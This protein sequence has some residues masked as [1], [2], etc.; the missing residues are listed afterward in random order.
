MTPTG[1]D[2]PLK[3]RPDI[4]GLRAVAVL[5]VVLF[6]LGLP[7]RGGYVGVD[8][9]FTI[10]GFLIGTIILRETAER[11]FTFAGFYER[12]IRRIFPALFAMLAVS[13]IFAFKYLLPLELVTY[14]RSL[15]AA[16]FSFSNIFFFFQSGYF[17][18]DAATKPL[19]HTWSLAVEEQFY[20]LLPILLVLLRRYLPRR[21]DIALYALTV[22]SFAI[23]LPGAYHHPSAT[24][25][26]PHTR[27]WEL[28]LG[29]VLSLESCPRIRKPILRN[30]GGIAGLALIAFAVFLYHSWTP[31]PGLAALPP[32]LGAALIIA[33]GRSGPNLAGRLLALRPV[34]FV[35]LISYSL[36]LWHWP[37]FVF[38]K[39]GFTLIRGLTHHQSQAYLLVLSLVLAI[40]SWRFIEVPFRTG[41]LRTGRRPLFAG[42]AVVLTASA[43]FA[44]IVAMHAGWQ[45][46]LSPQAA[47]ISSYIVEDTSV[48]VEQYRQ[49]TCFISE[50]SGTLADFHIDPCLTLQPGRKNLLLIGDSHAA[51]LYWGLAHTLPDTHVL[52]ATASGCKP[53]LHQ[54]PRQLSPCSEIMAYALNDFVLTHHVDALLLAAHWDEGDLPS[55]AETLTFL[56]QH[57]IPTILLGPIVQYDA[58]LPRLLTQSLLQ[59][60]PTLPARHR[61]ATIEPLDHQMANLAA[62]TGPTPYISLYNLF[63]QN[64]TCVEYA[65]P[66]TPLQA[67]YG[68]VTRAGSILT[69]QR[70]AA[71]HILP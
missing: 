53:V 63:C 32:C 68:H 25:Y 35:G 20:I 6:H 46:R 45:S 42:A 44:F 65:N 38:Y 29:T 61:L 31:F 23:A 62:T 30:A 54:R 13:S 12:R 7:L 34:V 37:V 58:S 36:Y 19:L 56:H 71:L 43:A 26:W 10:S 67:D 2:T 57:N 33:A 17:D 21:V 49:F 59:H 48:T 64:Q 69:A 27:A 5:S 24:F 11:R 51:D 70:I 50:S 18:T 39:Y 28:L 41:P 14:S 3:Y 40:L 1:V 60:D 8:I 9:F 55:V 4:D 52:Q 47:A 66:T 16:A 15:V 22:V